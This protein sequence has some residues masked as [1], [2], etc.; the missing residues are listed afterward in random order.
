MDVEEEEN[1]VKRLVPK[2]VRILSMR[3]LPLLNFLARKAHVFLNFLNVK[4][5]LYDYFRLRLLDFYVRKYEIDIIS[6][7]SMI[8]DEACCQLFFKRKPVVVTEHGQYAI[9]L[10][11][12]IKSFVNYLKKATTIITV[13]EYNRKL[14]GNELS[15]MGVKTETIYNGIKREVIDFGNFRK[16]HGI[17][18]DTFVFGMVSRGIPEKGWRFAIESFLKLKSEAAKKNLLVLVGGSSY[19]DELKEQYITEPSILFVGAVSN[20]TYYIKGFDVG[21]LPTVYEAESFPLAIIEYLFEGKPVIATDVGGIREM[22]FDGD[23]NAGQ[24]IPFTEDTNLFN[25]NLFIAMKQ[26]TVD[27]ILYQEHSKQAIELVKRFTIGE[28]SRNY[29]KVFDEILDTYK[30]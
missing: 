15:D 7:H 29:E 6:S 10:A 13:S 3:R 26:Y 4:R 5:S 19:L 8:S 20:P 22:L 14:F 18:D 24:L 9:H 1:L 21:L 27:T 17:P 25:E 28:C 12:G 16:D 30:Q 2:E 11:K 23:I